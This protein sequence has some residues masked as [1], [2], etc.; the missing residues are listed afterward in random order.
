MNARTAEIERPIKVA[1]LGFNSRTFNMLQMFFS[2][3]GKGLAELVSERDA[4]AAIF[5]LDALD[6]LQLWHKFARDGSRP[7]LVLSVKEQTLEK[8]VWVRKPLNL[9]TFA[10]AVDQLVQAC[11]SSATRLP[12]KIEGT[13]DPALV[14]RTASPPPSAPADSQPAPKR[15]LPIAAARVLNAVPPGPMEPAPGQAFEAAINRSARLLKPA[16]EDDYYHRDLRSFYGDRSDNHYLDPEKRDELFYDP[17]KYLQGILATE[18]ENTRRTGLAVRLEGLGKPLI[19]LADKNL[20]LSDMRDQYLRGLC[21]QPSSILRVSSS[22]AAGLELPAS[23]AAL[24]VRGESVLW[25][26]ALWTS[27]GRVPTGTALNQP[28]RLRRWPNFTRLSKTP[29]AVQ[30][31]AHWS[32]SPCSLSDTAEALQV[33]YRAV[34]GVFSACKALGLAD[35]DLGTMSSQRGGS[36]LADIPENTRRRLLGALL[37]KLG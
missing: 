9:D 32:R 22:R 21:T 31:V 35:Q 34:F 24:M 2:S 30:I 28:V 14:M 19:L 12:G 5:D 4:E 1:L 16:H 20:L 23:Q 13:A 6:G 10:H 8:A 36:P 33:P 17:D 25:K 7:A 18:L 3:Q 15:R 26:V 27:R 11:R 37:R 29:H